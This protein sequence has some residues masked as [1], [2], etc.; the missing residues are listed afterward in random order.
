MNVTKYTI[1]KYENGAANPSYEMLWK[2][3][4]F[5]NVSVD[6]LM[7]KNNSFNGDPITNREITELVKVFDSLSEEDKEKAI[8]MLKIFLN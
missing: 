2:L 4:D 7:G 3:A 1:N 5:F 6:Y 8:K